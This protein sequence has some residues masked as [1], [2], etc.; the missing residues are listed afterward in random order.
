MVCRERGI[1]FSWV[2]FLAVFVLH[3][4]G[5]SFAVRTFGGGNSSN[6]QHLRKSISGLTSPSKSKENLYFSLMQIKKSY[7]I[8]QY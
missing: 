2:Y 7:I 4:I 1:A 6:S 3:N 8:S 5:A